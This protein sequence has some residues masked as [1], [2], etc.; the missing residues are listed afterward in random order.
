MTAIFEDRG[1]QYRVKKDDVIAIDKI[2]KD[3]DEVLE[4]D[5]VLLVSD[6]ADLKI[7]APY[8]ASA[9]VTAKVVDNVRDDKVI[10][11]KFKRTKNYKRTRG[12]KQPY[13]MVKI[14]EIV[15]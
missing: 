13:T 11:F 9:K 10:V 7:G 4:F 14:Q 8:V 15:S 12:H 5:K 6:E 3:K 1:R 2:E